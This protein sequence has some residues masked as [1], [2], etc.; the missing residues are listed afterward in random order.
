VYFS[1]FSRR[2]SVGFGGS[3]GG[4]S[5]PDAAG[6]FWFCFWSGLYSSIL[7]IAIGEFTLPRNRPIAAEA[8]AV[9]V[10]LHVGTGHRR[11]LVA[12][13]PVQASAAFPAGSISRRPCSSRAPSARHPRTWPPRQHPIP[14]GSARPAASLRQWRI[15]TQPSRIGGSL[16]GGRSIGA[17]F[18]APSPGPQRRRRKSS[19]SSRL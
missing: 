5:S 16:A 8:A 3:G 12:G 15:Q 14:L 6:G 17:R 9:K 19:K 18:P 11:H 13:T 10:R 7:P 1:I 4:G 2:L